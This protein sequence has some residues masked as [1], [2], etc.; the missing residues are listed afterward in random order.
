MSNHFC[1]VVVR[2]VV[3][4]WSWLILPYSGEQICLGK[5]MGYKECCGWYNVSND[6]TKHHREA[7]NKHR[8]SP[9]G[10]PFGSIKTRWWSKALASSYIYDMRSSRPDVAGNNSSSYDNIEVLDAWVQSQQAAL[11]SS[12]RPLN[13]KW[14]NANHRCRFPHKPLS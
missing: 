8:I 5:E 11:H 13:W 2:E 6:I 14:G 4:G 3:N 9:P 12:R 10:N 7:E 1:A